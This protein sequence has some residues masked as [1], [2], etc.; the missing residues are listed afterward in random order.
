MRGRMGYCEGKNWISISKFYH[1]A[2]FSCYFAQIL[3]NRIGYMKLTVNHI[4]TTVY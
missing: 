2:I 1:K 3:R 4:M